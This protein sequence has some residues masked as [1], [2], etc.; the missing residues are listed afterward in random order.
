MTEEER[1]NS[2]YW[3]YWYDS[4]SYITRSL[5]IGNVLYTI[6]SSMV[7]MNNLDDLGEIRSLD[8]E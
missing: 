1:N 3:W 5:Y 4:Y 6:S 2:E 8:L 7:K